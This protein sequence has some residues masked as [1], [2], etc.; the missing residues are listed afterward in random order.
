MATMTSN[1]LPAISADRS[2]DFS[3]PDFL[4][5]ELSTGVS[6]GQFQIVSYDLILLSFCYS[7]KWCL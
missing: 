1:F 3:R 4:T 7:T 6:V 5:E 2:S